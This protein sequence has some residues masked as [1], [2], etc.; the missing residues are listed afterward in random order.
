[1]FLGF[2]NKIKNVAVKPEKLEIAI[3]HIRDGHY[4]EA[5]IL[6]LES[7]KR[8]D[9]V[10]YVVDFISK[11]HWR[12]N[13]AALDIFNKTIH[14]YFNDGSAKGLENYLTQLSTEARTS[15]SSHSHVFHQIRVDIINDLLHDNA[16]KS[17]LSM[18]QTFR[19][20]MMMSKAI[21]EKE[22]KIKYSK[23]VVDAM[24]KAWPSNKS[25]LKV[26]YG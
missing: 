10:E 18:A 23:T 11:S 8:T 4:D 15:V 16:A 25:M 26:L 14:K 12:I 9:R 6:A 17:A 13:S 20:E 2:L 19:M 1:M 21:T 24:S 5:L 7:M 3:G 22:I